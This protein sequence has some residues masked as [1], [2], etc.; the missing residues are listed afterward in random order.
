[1]NSKVTMLIMYN[2]NPK[3]VSLGEK[4]LAISSWDHL[5]QITNEC[6]KWQPILW[7]I[8]SY[9]LEK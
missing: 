2:K 1:M 8:Q 3:L 6:K 7:S 9:S 5:A 4:H